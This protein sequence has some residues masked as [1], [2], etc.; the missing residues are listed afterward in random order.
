[1]NIKPLSDRVVLQPVVVDNKTSSGI[2]IPDMA[3]EKPK[4]GTVV[5][6]GP[7]TK[8]VIVGDKVIYNKNAGTDVLEDGV[9]YLLMKEIDIMAVI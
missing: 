3:I 2:I 6:I 4:E 9:N 7:E 1:M 5:A 8:W